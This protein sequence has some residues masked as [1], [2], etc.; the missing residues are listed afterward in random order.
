MCGDFNGDVGFLGGHRSTRPPS[1][2]GTLV[3]KF[4]N[5]LGLFPANLDTIAAGPINTFK[6]GMG[7]ST[8]DYIAIPES[9]RATLMSCNVLNECILNTSDHFAVEVSLG[10]KCGVVNSCKTPRV[11]KPLW[12]KANKKGLLNKYRD[13]IINT[14]NSILLKWDLGTINN[15]EIDQVFD[16]LIAG[17]LRADRVIPRSNTRFHA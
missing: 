4:L 8:L 7:S 9:L 11:G 17:I 15:S 1:K 13:Y 10:I 16:D 5:E 3:A 12:G 6:G 14:M 2:Q